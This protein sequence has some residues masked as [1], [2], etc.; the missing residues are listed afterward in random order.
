M[1]N[2]NE[3]FGQLKLN[4]QG[5]TTLMLVK[6]LDANKLSLSAV[7][8]FDEIADYPADV[9]LDPTARASLVA[10]LLS[11]SLNFVAVRGDKS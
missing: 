11:K 4:C 1:N 8:I 3:A 6:A 10:D 7:S 5:S 9:L 2:F